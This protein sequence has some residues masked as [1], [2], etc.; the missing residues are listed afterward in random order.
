MSTVTKSLERKRILLSDIHVDPDTNARKSYAEDAMKRLASSIKADNLLNPVVVRLVTDEEKKDGI[1]KPYFLLAGFRRVKAHG[2]EYLNRDAIDATV[3]DPE[4]KPVDGAI[5]GLV[6]NLN[7]EGLST[8][9]QAV[10]FV[11]VRDNFKLSGE[12]IAQRIRGTTE[13]GKG[14][15]KSTINN[16]MRIYDELHPEIRTAWMERKDKATVYNFLNLILPKGDHDA[17]W[18]AWEV[19]NGLRAADGDDG[20]EETDSDEDEEGDEDESKAPKRR[21]PSLDAIAQA[22]TDIRKGENDE[23]WKKGAL[24]ALNWARAKTATISGLEKAPDKKGSK[25]SKSAGRG[26]AEA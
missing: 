4:T 23:E 25:G 24:A 26:S 8:Y 14:Y 9:E 12:Q 3:L 17:Q 10:G 19:L 21:R 22:M 20:D 5:I 16:Y 2:P 1:A 18:E 7:R 6:D 11:Q 15:S 13:E